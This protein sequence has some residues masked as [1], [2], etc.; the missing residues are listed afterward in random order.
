MATGI[1]RWLGGVAFLAGCA[2]GSS[3][4]AFPEAS[5]VG[6]YDFTA[7]LPFTSGPMRLEGTFEVTRDTVLLV[8]HAAQCQV[9]SD[10][11]ASFT[12]G[13]EGA[14]YKDASY[15]RVTFDRRLPLQ[16]VTVSAMITTLVRQ[17]VCPVSS[18]QPACVS[19]DT[20]KAYREERRSVHPQ[21][22]PRKW[23]PQ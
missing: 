12:Y 2:A 8:M 10:S 19:Q 7:T 9:V 4:P 1:R 22:T 20:A 17:Q 16:H 15:I 13:C 6:L 18:E 5:A 11:R 14:T 21:V 3:G 23:E